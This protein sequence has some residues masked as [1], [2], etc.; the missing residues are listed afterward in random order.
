M[1]LDIIDFFLGH[2]GQKKKRYFWIA[3]NVTL[4][5]SKKKM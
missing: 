1:D 5:S 2:N 3:D 4:P